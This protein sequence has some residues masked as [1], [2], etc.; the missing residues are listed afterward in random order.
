M[1]WCLHSCQRLLERVEDS[2]GFCFGFCSPI[3]DMCFELVHFP[4]DRPSNKCMVVE[5]ICAN[6]DCKNT[7][8][9]VWDS[10]SWALEKKS[11]SLTDSEWEH[12][13]FQKAT[14]QEW[15]AFCAPHLCTRGCLLWL[16]TSARTTSCLHIFLKQV[17]CIQTAGGNLFFND[18][19]W[20][21]DMI[22][23]V[24]CMCGL[25]PRALY[26]FLMLRGYLQPFSVKRNADCTKLLFTLAGSY[27][28]LPILPC[29]GLP[30]VGICVHVRQV[31]IE[32]GFSA[33]WHRTMFGF[34]CCCINFI[35]YCVHCNEFRQ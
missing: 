14:K 4:P 10:L 35:V 31:S 3:P 22:L 17:R 18:S 24:L 32:A 29:L 19:R 11:N 23:T 20:F 8:I 27:I 15:A 12:R 33:P 16:I 13:W 26:K 28:L 5:W 7:A 30:R 6:N 1:I 34:S 25:H 2:R 21:T 9:L